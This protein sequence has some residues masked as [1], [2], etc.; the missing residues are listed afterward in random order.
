MRRLLLALLASTAVFAM[1]ATEVAAA[2]PF[3]MG[4]TE[5]NTIVKDA[6]YRRGR[7]AVAYRGP[8]G[9]YRGRAVVAG[10]RRVYGGRAVYARRGG[11]Y[12][13]GTG[14]YAGSNCEPGY[15]PGGYY[16]GALYR[17]GGVVVRRGAYYGR[18]GFV[19]GRGAVAGRRFAARGRGIRRR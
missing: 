16:G 13:G 19:A 10:G 17:R 12:V 1:A 18:R 14:Y 15:C 6:A 9:A 3:G 5:G 11:V 8:A 7:G 2:P 4:L